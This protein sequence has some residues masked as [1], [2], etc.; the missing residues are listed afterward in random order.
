MALSSG[1]LG[2]VQAA[3]R[4]IGRLTAQRFRAVVEFAQGRPSSVDRQPGQ[5]GCASA[6]SRAAR[7][8]VLAPVSEWAAQELVVALSISQPTAQ[9]MLT[10]ALVL[11]QQLPSTLA[12]L[13]SGLIH[14]G[15]LPVF[16][17]SVAAITDP[18]VRAAVEADLLGWVTGRVKTPAQLRERAAR[19]ILRLDAAG[20]ARRLE[21]A[22]R[23]RGVYDSPGRVAGM[24]Q[25]TAV[26]T[27][28]EARACLRVLAAYADSIDDDIDQQGPDGR[29]LPRRTRA[30]KMADVLCD[31][32]LRP[33]HLGAPA[34]QAQVTLVATVQTLAGGDQPGEIDGQVVPAEM[35]RHLARVLGLVPDLLADAATG[36]P[37]P[38]LDTPRGDRAPD[39]RAPLD[40]PAPAPVRHRVADP[41]TGWREAERWEQDWQEAAERAG[42][43]CDRPADADAERRFLEEIWAFEAAADNSP[44]PPQVIAHQASAPPTRPQRTRSTDTG[45]TSPEAGW[46]AADAAV[47]TASAVV[48]EA[49]RAVA[50]AQRQVEVAE[51]RTTDDERAWTASTAGRMTHAPDSIAALATATRGQRAAIADLLTRTAGGGLADRPRIAVVEAL[52]GTLLALTD[53]PE[54]RRLAHCA[55]PACARRTRACAHDLT[56]APG[57]AAP[58]E[59]DGYRPS[60]ALDRFVRAR[61]RRCRFPGCRQPVPGGGEL[62]H[63]RP[64]PDGPTAAGN[65]AGYC[66]LNHRGKHQAP[67]WTHHLHPDG[68]LTITTPTGLTT[69][70]E[71][72]DHDTRPVTT[73]AEPAP[74]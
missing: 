26:L 7:P 20:A 40:P 22:I 29:P 74:F 1:P 37:T 35:V 45:W 14:P 57:L 44:S 24:A 51:R 55:R 23:Q 66:S 41:V 13:E 5:P 30:Q 12:A 8:E 15:H 32:I 17:D 62:D 50:V 9:R 2:A 4:E 70:T 72:E 16:L 54:L 48:E 61:D 64:Y 65:L 27:S 43:F 46:S 42:R 34:S 53:A 58:P 18:A 47:R 3:D 36:S 73:P 28:P 31:L 38:D 6:A 49:R 25:L 63:D 10:Q 21:Q 39:P 56:D 59:T 71:P 19:V 60:S 69:I 52:T 68:R 33:G 67:G 11:V